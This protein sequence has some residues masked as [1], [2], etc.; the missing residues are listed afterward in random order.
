MGRPIFWTRDRRR[1]LTDLAI[2]L[3]LDSD[4]RL[5]HGLTPTAAEL[6]FGFD[7]EALPAVEL[8]LPDGRVLRVR[9]RIDRVDRGVDGAV[10]VVDYKTGSLRGGYAD[11]TPDNPVVGGSRLQLPIYGLAGRLAAADPAAAVTAEY[12]FATTKGGFRR[13]GYDVTPEVLETTIEVLDVIVR[14]VEGGVFPPHP[15]ALSTFLW[16][17]CH[18]C[19]PDGLGTGELR[20]QWERKRWDPALAEYAQLAEPLERAEAEA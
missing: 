20:R 7:G 6:G 3:Q 8:T 12:W 19:D 15:S 4:H 16:V 13:A 11:L 5:A 10:H 1:I 9:G 2:A 14:G 17:E 18:T